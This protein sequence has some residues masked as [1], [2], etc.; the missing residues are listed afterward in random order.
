MIATFV[1]KEAIQRT[2]LLTFD[3]KDEKELTTQNVS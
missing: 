3:L 1:F 2:K